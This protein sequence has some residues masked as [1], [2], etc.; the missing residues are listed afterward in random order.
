MS[1]FCILLAFFCKNVKRVHMLRGLITLIVAFSFIMTAQAQSLEF[2]TIRTETTPGFFALRI[3]PGNDLKPI[4]IENVYITNYQGRKQTESFVPILE[5]LRELNATI[6]APEQADQYQYDNAYRTIWLGSGP[7]GELLFSPQ[8]D[9]IL[10]DFDAFSETNLGPVYLQ[11][12]DLKFGGNVSDV[13]PERIRFLGNQGTVYGKFER[14]LKTRLE[15]QA[16]TQSQEIAAVTPIYLN[17]Y[18][19]HTEARSLPAKWEAAYK[20]ATSK[21][22]GKRLN[23]D[24][25]LKLFPWVLFFTG[26]ALI[27]FASTRIFRHREDWYDFAMNTESNTE[28]KTDSVPQRNDSDHLKDDW[29]NHPIEETPLY[30]DWEKNLPF[31]VI[32]RQED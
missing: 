17:D 10:S 1:A 23:Y 7:A 29:W 32:N 19:A 21:D 20:A 22:T 4:P 31:E 9:D 26:L 8:S 13:Y 15:L 27:L 6:I 14:P 3:F 16:T 28:P 12:L 24:W 18:E 30:K 11:N 2:E 5:L 25:W